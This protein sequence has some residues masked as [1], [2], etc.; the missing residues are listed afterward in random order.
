M[1]DWIINAIWKKKPSAF[2]ST[3]GY[4]KRHGIYSR[5]DTATSAY[6]L[7]KDLN[8]EST[9]AH[10]DELIG[11]LN[12]I[13]YASNTN[14]YFHFFFPIVSHILFYRN[15]READIIGHLTGPNFA[16]GIS[17]VQEMIEMIQGAMDFKLKENPFYLS[18]EGQLWVK[19]LLPEMREEIGREIEK[20]KRE[21][22]D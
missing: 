11:S 8:P 5:N 20:R 9:Q 14:G 1:I 12:G 7:L 2:E 22:E 18:K 10:V 4:L 6:D 13:R 17:D 19:N 3:F 16:N 15:D 21:L